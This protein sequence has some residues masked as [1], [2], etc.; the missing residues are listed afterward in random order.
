MAQLVDEHITLVNTMSEHAPRP[1]RREGQVRCLARADHRLPRAD[2]RQLG[3]HPGHRQGRAEDGGEMAGDVEDDR[4]PARARRRR[5]PAWSARTCAPASRRS[6]CR[7]SSR[8]SA[9]I[10]SCRNSSVADAMG[11]RARNAVDTATT[12]RAVHAP[13]VPRAADASWTATRQRRAA[14]CRFRSNGRNSRCTACRR[15]SRSHRRRRSHGPP[16]AA[17]L[18]RRS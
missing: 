18:R 7:D 15:E 2:R 16:V 3:Q 17:R 14:R 4:G 5:S 12:A 10:S 9:R 13:G 8:P 11:L 1:R 6:R